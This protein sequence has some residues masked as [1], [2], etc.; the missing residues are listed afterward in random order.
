MRNQSLKIENAR[1]VVTVDTQRRII[2]DGS[3]LI[4][5]GRISGVG[6]A[7]DLAGPRADLVIDARHRGV[8]P[9]FFIGHVHISYPHAVRCIFPD[10]LGSQLVQVVKLLADMTESAE[11]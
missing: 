7:A 8:T 5:G 3:I 1:Y 10:D 2:Q 11:N 4:E 6:K 9:G